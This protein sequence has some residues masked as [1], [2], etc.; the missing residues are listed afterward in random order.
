MDRAARA[1]DG[2]DRM[3]GPDPAT[4][5]WVPI[6]NPQ[7]QGPVGPQ[8]QQGEQGD[9]GDP[10]QIGA[11]G[12]VGPQGPQ[13][14]GGTG[15]AGPM[16]TPGDAG[17]PGEPGPPGPPGAPGQSGATFPLYS[18][19]DDFNRADESPL[20]GTG[21][22]QSVAYFS[23][24]FRL[25]S[26]QIAT[27]SPATF[28]GM[29]WGTK[30]D[31]N[32]NAYVDIPVLPNADSTNVK[33]SM[34][35][36]LIGN[37]D[38]FAVEFFSSGGGLYAYLYRYTAG[39]AAALG[40]LTPFP[41]SPG[42]AIGIDRSGTTIRAWYRK[43]GVWVKAIEA[44]DASSQVPL[45]PSV[46]INGTVPRVDNFGGGPVHLGVAVGTTDLR[47]VGDYVPGT[48][49]NDGDIVIGADGNTYVCTQDNVT[50]APETWPLGVAGVV[51][52]HHATHEPGGTDPIANAAWVNFANIFTQPQ[53][54]RSGSSPYA[55]MLLQD[56]TAPAGAQVFD[57]INTVQAL[58]L[59][60]LN[61][62]ASA[63]VAVPLKLWRDGGVTVG[64]DIA[65]KGR[66]IPIGHWIDYPLAGLITA[67]VGTVTLVTQYCSEYTL[68]GKTC[69]YNFY[70]ALNLSSTPQGIFIPLPSGITG[71]PT[72]YK[73]VPFNYSGGGI[74]MA[75]VEPDGTRVVLYRDNGGSVNWPVASN[76]VFNGSI[77]FRI[78]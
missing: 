70:L 77:T 37:Q 60:A 67:N 43:N 12:P 35:V 75:Q 73:G 53:T 17:E 29:A 22:W 3:S 36:S 57:I 44:V 45:Y 55:Q 69:I 52:P 31:L 76:W 33:L 63:V 25:V 48:T 9:P 62:A 18:I 21:N 68:I 8:G 4:T 66:A 32:F 24:N 40:N 5:E 34:L 28:G 71:G 1:T 42:D 23:G 30:L 19:L 47:Y 6:W 41:L 11:T 54:L 64:K 50:T 65:E 74:G 58:Y 59:R 46:S 7:S 20:S 16:G 51:G 49:Y 78:A 61:D 26:N 13:G 14:A 10:G 15:P 38:G 27:I 2:D 72:Y 56:L 39:S